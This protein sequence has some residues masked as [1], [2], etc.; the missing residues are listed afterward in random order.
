MEPDFHENALRQQTFYCEGFRAWNKLFESNRGHNQGDFV[1]SV[2]F[3]KRNN[4]LI[5]PTNIAPERPLCQSF[6]KNAGT[7]VIAF[8][9]CPSSASSVIA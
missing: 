9:I 7:G 6:A 3:R 2:S 5:R 4:Q 8:W 1:E